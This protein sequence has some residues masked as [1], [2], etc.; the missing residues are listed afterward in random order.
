M[1]QAEILALPGYSRRG[2]KKFARKGFLEE[3]PGSVL[4]FLKLSRAGLTSAMV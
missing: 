2:K 3:L 1:P 4:G